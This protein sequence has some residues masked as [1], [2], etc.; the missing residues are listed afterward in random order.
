MN[1]LIESPVTQKRREMDK[2]VPELPLA[3]ALRVMGV[4]P[5]ENG[6]VRDF[7]RQYKEKHCRTRATLEGN[8][9]ILHYSGNAIA[10]FF[11]LVSCGL[12][13]NLMN[14]L[15]LSFPAW[16]HVLKAAGAACGAIVVFFG[17]KLYLYYAHKRL[18]E[19][20]VIFL[21]AGTF[22]EIT[23]L[24]SYH[25]ISS[26]GRPSVPPETLALAKELGQRV[27]GVA[28]KVEYFYTDP[29]LWAEYGKERIC[30]AHWGEE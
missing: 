28:L 13:W 7:Q 10:A 30:I 26:F 11:A 29:F 15:V 3:H 8:D 1:T 25:P 16:I 9:G 17:L 23:L 12:V 6:W 24:E 5:F 18:I 4:E 20:R 2:H 14:P 21:M 19:R 22:W 27:P